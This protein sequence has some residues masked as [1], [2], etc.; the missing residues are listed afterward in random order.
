[1]QAGSNFPQEKG[2]ERARS[3]LYALPLLTGSDSLTGHLAAASQEGILRHGGT[4]LPRERE[5]LT[6]RR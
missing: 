4:S 3:P 2:Q 6:P 5:S 1:M